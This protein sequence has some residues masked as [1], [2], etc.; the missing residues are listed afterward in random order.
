MSAAKLERLGPRALN[1][2]LLARQLLLRRSALPVPKAIEHL[3][4]LQAQNPKSPYFALWSRLIGFRPELLGGLVAERKA[5]RAVLMRST[6]HLATARDCLRLCPSLVPVLERNLYTGSPYGRRI[7][8]V[9]VKRLL[10]V[11]RGLVE[12]RPRTLS[13]L[14]KLLVEQW[15]QHDATSLAYAVH[16]LLPMVQVPP[17]GVWGQS[18]QAAWT[19][20][21]AWLGKPLKRRVSVE[22]LFLRYLAAF[23]PASARDLQ[24][25][26]GLN[27][28][29]EVAE[30]LRP[31]LRA[32]RDDD[33][34]ELLDLPGAPRPSP[35]T[36]A[37]VRFLPDFDNVFLSHADRTRIITG[38]DARRFRKP[39]N[40]AA[41]GMVLIDGFIR[42]T[43]TLQQERAKTTLFVAPFSRPSKA[44]CRGVIEEGERLLAFAAANLAGDVRFVSGK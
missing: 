34:I 7:R 28:V 17:R 42:A 13:E 31:K 36:P 26:S 44:D 22:A 37:P 12:A 32:F 6:L 30:R 15:P 1:R 3:V 2:A 40:V 5:V 10:A 33:G 27:G 18:G 4:A 19:T 20:V 11:A 29:R 25:W 9:D 35:E 16:N 14:R 21:E 38:E 8:G 24:Q 23:G 39:G 41:P 43:W